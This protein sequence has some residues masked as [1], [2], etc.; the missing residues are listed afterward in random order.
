M[1]QKWRVVAAM[2]LL[3]VARVLLGRFTSG[4]GEKEARR[5][6]PVTPPAQAPAAQPPSVATG[7]QTTYRVPID[8]SPT[9][10]PDD[11]LVTIVEFS[12]FQCPFCGRVEPTLKQIESTYG[13]KVRIVWRNSPLP[14]HQNADPAAQLAMEAFKQKGNDGFWKMHDT[15]FTNQAALER[16]NLESYAQQAGLDMTKVRQALD[17]KTNAAVIKADMDVGAQFG[18]RGTPNFYINGR[19]L[20]RARPFDDFKKMIDEELAL[21]DSL[22]KKGVSKSQL[23]ASITKDGLKQFKAAEAPQQ[24]GAPDPKTVYKIELTGKEP[25]R[26][27]NDALVTI[28]EISDFECPFCGRVTPTMKQIEDKYGKDVRVVWW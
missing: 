14:F 17:N 15:L 19:Q 10:G 27:S 9:R 23:Y 21:A 25:Q 26:G 3:L 5:I 13:N 11:A 24:P 1:W 12:D 8:D 20:T 16:E 22:L 18:A 28:V 2:L 7:S 4:S 6:A